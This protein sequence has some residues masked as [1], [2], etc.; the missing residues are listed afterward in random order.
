ME[1]RLAL[2]KA[3]IHHNLSILA[4]L[5]QRT[6]EEKEQGMC[7]EASMLI[8]EEEAADRVSSSLQGKNGF[9]K[10]LSLGTGMQFASRSLLIPT[11]NLSLSITH[12]NL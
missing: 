6:K 4:L 10:L 5:P 9:A 12:N 11:A 8:P 7:S 1:E 3:D 2:D